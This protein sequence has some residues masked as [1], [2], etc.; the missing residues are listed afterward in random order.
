MEL[1]T[2]VA[3]VKN[4]KDRKIKTATVKKDQEPNI[5]DFCDDEKEDDLAPNIPI[6]KYK[7]KPIRSIENGQLHRLVASFEKL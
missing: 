2:D 4:K 1:N 7:F 5:E 3:N 6:P